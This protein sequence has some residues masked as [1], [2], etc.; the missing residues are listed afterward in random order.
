MTAPTKRRLAAAADA[1][2]EQISR[3]RPHY[4]LGRPS[5]ADQIGALRAAARA[6]GLTMEDLCPQVG[7]CAGPCKG[8]SAAGRAALG[9]KGAA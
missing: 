4:I 5:E 1:Y 8:H 9:R 7:L 3:H 2:H 6:H